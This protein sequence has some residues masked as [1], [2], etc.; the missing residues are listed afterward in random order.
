MLR[1]YRIKDYDFKL[2]VMLIAISI[3]GILAVDDNIMNIMHIRQILQ[4]NEINVESACSATEAFERMENSVFSLI[5]LDH[6]MPDI[7]GITL[8]KKMREKI[9]H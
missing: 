2:V 5:L 9:Q 3:I 7:D 1:K 8:L 6:M 4:S